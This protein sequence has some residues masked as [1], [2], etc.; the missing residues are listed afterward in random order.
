MGHVSMG[1]R[2]MGPCPGPNGLPIGGQTLV[3]L[4]HWG[5]KPGALLEN[6]YATIMLFIT[7]KQEHFQSKQSTFFGREKNRDRGL[8][9]KV[10]H[11]GPGAI[12]PA[13][14]QAIPMRP[15]SMQS[16]HIEAATMA[17][18]N[19]LTAAEGRIFVN[20]Y[21]SFLTSWWTLAKINLQTAAEG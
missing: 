18:I 5:P 21:F 20:K 4:G 6:S 3:W 1:P 10:E 9:P 12:I 8:A 13:Q 19:S 16:V 17:K 2:R 14:G 7:G 15:N 11:P